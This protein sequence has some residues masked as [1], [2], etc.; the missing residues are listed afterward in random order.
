MVVEAWSFHVPSGGGAGFH[1]TPPGSLG[2]RELDS[3]QAS[4]RASNQRL[5]R[6][7]QQQWLRRGVSAPQA[8]PDTSQNMY[9]HPPQHRSL[10]GTSQQPQCC[11]SARRTE[12]RAS[13]RI[14]FA[15]P[16]RATLRAP[17]SLQ[18]G[19][20]SRRS[21]RGSPTLRINCRATS[22]AAPTRTS[23]SASRTISCANRLPTA[24][25]SFST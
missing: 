14:L 15:A 25:C 23:T 9:R 17:R 1:L 10:A 19:G 12:L 6:A 21:Q 13:V 3:L 20:V 22:L 11:R 18:L 16:I 24:Q 4:S 8:S 7:S 5:L 2:R